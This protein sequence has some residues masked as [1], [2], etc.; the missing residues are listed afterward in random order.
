MIAAGPAAKRPPHMA[1]ASTFVAG[2]ADFCF[3]VLMLL[4]KTAFLGLLCSL[5]LGSAALADNVSPKL[6]D[7]TR[8]D[9]PLPTPNED[10]E[11]ALGAKV[12]L[13]DFKGR[14]VVLNFWASWCAP[15]IAEMP[16]LDALQAELG[17]DGLDVVAVSLD[18]DG[19]K[20]AAPFFRKS[21][22]KHLKL[23]TDRLSDL[24]QELKGSALPTTYVLDRD[25]KVVA[26]YIGATNWATDEIKAELRKYLDAKPAG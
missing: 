14:V 6:G 15:C 18:R 10:F 8:F 25:G 22:I 17:P 12:T 4:K 3:W 24:F 1:F 21:G 16:T 5:F 23:Y 20:K 9:P 19:I 7:F 11:D 26:A 13:A 2:L